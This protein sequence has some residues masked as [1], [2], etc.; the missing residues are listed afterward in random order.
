[1]VQIGNL[2]CEVANDSLEKKVNTVYLEH[3]NNSNFKIILKANGIGYLYFG[4][5]FCHGS[6]NGFITKDIP[7]MRNLQHFSFQVLGRDASFTESKNQFDLVLPPFTKYRGYIDGFLNNCL[8]NF[9]INQGT[10]E[11]Y[12]YTNLAK[13]VHFYILFIHMTSGFKTGLNFN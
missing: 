5:P 10:S 12:I 3:T 4:K 8:F 11:K 1:M 7:K 13:D 6:E 9:S 2:M